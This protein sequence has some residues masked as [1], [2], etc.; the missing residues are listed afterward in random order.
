[1]KQIAVLL[2][3]VYT[4][5]AQPE[6][7]RD[8]SNQGLEAYDRHDYASAESL[9][10]SAVAMWEAL[11]EAYAPHLGIT[12]MNLAQVLAVLGHR[13]ESLAEL[14]QAV[15]LLHRALGPRAMQT[16]VAMNLLAGLDLMMG[17]DAGAQKL[18]DETLPI[19]REI[20][21]AGVQSSRALAGLACLRMRDQHFDEALTLA[22]EALRIAIHA[23]GEDSVDTALAYG[24]VAEV[25]RSA[26]RPERALPLY[27]HA[28]AIYQKLLGPQDTRVAAILT[29][30]ALILIDDHKYAL[31][32]EQLKQSLTILGH[33]CPACAIE[34][35]NAESAIGLLRT[36]QGKYGEADRL[37][38][39]LLAQQEATQPQPVAE[40]A[41][42]LNSLAF[43]RRKERLFEDA[44]RLTNR[45]ATL[46]F[47]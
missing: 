45:A 16:L 47:R 28:R 40:I 30:E 1:M 34:R 18:L 21:P 8:L 5:S 7:A 23:T 19:A 13:A 41:V 14:R 36:R 42:T 4:A 10:R 26:G 17:D 29:Q 2:F 33:S 24:T 39:R 37:F 15:T 22:D 35:W 25:H 43:V 9:D 44:D 38:T 6:A 11:G 27:R 12:R 3:V 32:E 20:D 46:S 31:A